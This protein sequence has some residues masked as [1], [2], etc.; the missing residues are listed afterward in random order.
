MDPTGTWL[1]FTSHRSGDGDI[2][3]IR[4]GELLGR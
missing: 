3:R 4:L 2:Y 1:Y